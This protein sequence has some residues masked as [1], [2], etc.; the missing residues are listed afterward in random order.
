[1]F[2]YG[3]N[4]QLVLLVFSLPEILNCRHTCNF[5]SKFVYDL[6]TKFSKPSHSGLPVTGDYSIELYLM[7]FTYNSSLT[8]LRFF[9]IGHGHSS[10]LFTRDRPVTAH[11]CSCHSH[12]PRARVFNG[13]AITV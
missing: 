1:M 4:S 8:K 12:C 10:L 11:C 6:H 3:A 7:Q 13:K 9:E 5:Y 2:N